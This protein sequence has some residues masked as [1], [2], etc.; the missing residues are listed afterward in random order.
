MDKKIEELIPFYALGALTDEEKE[1]VESYLRE[2]PDARKEADELQSAASKLPFAV[3][4]AEPPQRVKAAL[5]KRV[6]AD[7]RGTERKQAERPREKRWANLFPALSLAVAV[8][9]VV[10]AVGLNVQVMRLQEKVSLLG[11][12]LAAQSDSLEEINSKLPQASPVVTVS[13]K[14]TE[15]QPQAR[16]ELIAD[17]AS[18]SGVLVIAGLSQLEPGKTYQVWL[19]DASGPKSAGLLT[20][21]SNGQAVLVVTSELTIGEF[22]ALGIS[23]EP[24]GGS[25]Q[26]TGEIVVLSDL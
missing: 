17:E 13:L 22:D 23:I 4:S 5:M 8:F 11:E 7:E 12:A 21:D 19:I 24:E 25:D 15:V 2:N 6:R 1:L 10:W 18:N 16:G 26:P 9:A 20:V 3:E 14:G